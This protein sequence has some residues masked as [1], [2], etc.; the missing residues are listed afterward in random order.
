[1]DFT[2]NLSIENMECKILNG[3]KLNVKVNLKANICIYLNAEKRLLKSINNAKNIQMISSKIEVNSLKGKGETIAVAKDTISIDDNLVDILDSNIFIRNKD[4]KISYNK[5]LSKADVIVEIMYLDD[6]EQINTITS[7]IPVMGFIDINEISENEIC[8]TTYEM[9][10]INIKPENMDE[11]AISVEIEFLI[12]CNAYENK[13]I[14]LIQ[15]LYSPEEDIT[16]ND[17]NICIMRDKNVVES[18]YQSKNKINIPEIKNGRIYSVKII[19]IINKQSITNDTVSYSGELVINVLFE[20]SITNRLEIKSERAAFSYDVSNSNIT[21]ETSITT[22]VEVENKDFVCMQDNTVE[23]NADIV[24][25][26]DMYN[27]KNINIVND[28]KIEP[29]SNNNSR[30]SLVVYFVKEGDTLWKIAKK[31]KSTIDEI[32]QIN[33][34]EDVNNL[35]IGSQLFIPKYM[36]NRIL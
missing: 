29:I 3:R 26:M 17:E 28:V 6:N 5:V 23:V 35:K 11:H 15:D 25:S 13:D 27:K 16:L 1:M 14:N 9:R 4:L 20:S 33:N 30:N 2:C 10:N 24:F 12:S 19:P 34:I 7:Q 22:N 21:K 18:R 36:C 32:A 31:F 8:S